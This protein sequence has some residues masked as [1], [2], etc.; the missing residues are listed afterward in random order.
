MTLLNSSPDLLVW[1]IVGLFLYDNVSFLGVDEYL[2][3]GLEMISDYMSNMNIQPL[4][5]DSLLTHPLISTQ[6]TTT[7]ELL[8]PEPD[9]DD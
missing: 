1:I 4:I 3:P 6:S 7:F 8:C 2:N 9:S 5:R